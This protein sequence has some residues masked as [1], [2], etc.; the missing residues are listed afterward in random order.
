DD[1]VVLDVEAKSKT[2][3]EAPLRVHVSNPMRLLGLG[4]DAVRQMGE[5]GYVVNYSLAV[6]RGGK[7]HKINK[8]NIPLD[9][10]IKTEE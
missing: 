10:F 2:E 6:S 5:E 8:K 9:S 7:F 1:G 3:L 4:L